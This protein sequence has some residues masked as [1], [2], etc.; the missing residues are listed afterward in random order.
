M[1]E[2]AKKSGITLDYGVKTNW[3]PVD[4]QRALLWAGRFGKQE[5]FVDALGR[6]H[7]EQRKSAA[8]RATIL[9]SASEV[10][11]DVDALVAF[12]DTDELVDYVWQSY[13]DTI[14]KHHVHAIP[15]FVFGFDDMRSPFRP[16]GKTESVTVRGSANVDTFFSIFVSLL[17]RS[18][19]VPPEQ[20]SA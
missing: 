9:E 13:G 5:E 12:L 4:S 6:R 3:Q 20:A 11:L 14:K 10:G 1:F 18:L 17:D 2:L 16:D 8:H 19:V 15:Y 7:F